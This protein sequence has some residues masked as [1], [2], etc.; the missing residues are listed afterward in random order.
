MVGK[1]NAMVECY[2][3]PEI[4]D[5]AG[6]TN[7]RD[8]ENKAGDALAEY[9]RCVAVRFAPRFLQDEIVAKILAST[10]AEMENRVR[11]QIKLIMQEYR[12]KPERP[13]TSPAPD[14]PAEGG[15]SPTS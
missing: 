10:S 14:K 8:T 1:S 5:D 2:L 9:V 7:G 6:G 4:V 11:Q 15:A 13:A 3:L 12:R